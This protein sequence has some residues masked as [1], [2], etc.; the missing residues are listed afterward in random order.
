MHGS[1]VQCQRCDACRRT[2]PIAAAS[3]PGVLFPASP[4]VMLP[5][6]FPT[7]AAALSSSPSVV[8]TAPAR[9]ASAVEAAAPAASSST[10]PTI[11]RSQESILR[12]VTNQD[13]KITTEIAN[14]QHSSKRIPTPCPAWMRSRLRDWADA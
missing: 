2:N 5:A 9:V 3:S 7:T 4:G 6:S 14:F 12:R 11:L 1:A 8:V 10:A 13:A